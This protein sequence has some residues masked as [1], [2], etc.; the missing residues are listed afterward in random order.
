MDYCILGG[1]DSV[2]ALCLINKLFYMADDCILSSAFMTFTFDYQCCVTKA[3]QNKVSFIRGRITFPYKPEDNLDLGE[4]YTILSEYNFIP[5][6]DLD[7]DKQGIIMWKKEV[8][9]IFKEATRKYLAQ[10]E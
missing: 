1:G 5:E 8:P 10:E 6:R 2:M 7:F 4:V 3:F 9:S